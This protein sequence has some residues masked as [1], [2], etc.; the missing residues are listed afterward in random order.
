LFR[1]Y[2]GASPEWVLARYR[3]HDAAARLE[4]E[5]GVPIAAVA[6][7]VGYFDQAHFCREFKALLAV[8]PAEYAAQCRDTPANARQTA[9]GFLLTKACKPVKIHGLTSANPG[10]EYP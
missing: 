10:D 7:A 5:P 9:P 1:R 3:L 4:R 6:A 8:T 2:L